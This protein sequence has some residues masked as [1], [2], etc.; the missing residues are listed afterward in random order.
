MSFK[1]I[2]EIDG[3]E[4]LLSRMRD[5]ET[6][7]DWSFILQDYLSF[8]NSKIADN[9]AIF[10][11]NAA[12]DCPNRES[13]NCQVPWEDC[14]AGKAERQYPQPL[15]YRRRQEYL[16]DSMPPELWAEAFLAVID[17][18][19]KPVDTIRF[20]EAGDFRHNADIVRVD[21]IA[22]ILADHGIDVY[23]YSASDYL[24]WSLAENF[25]VNAS[26]P[27]FDNANRRYMAVDAGE[28]LP[29]GAVWCPYDL[30]DGEK[31]CGD[32]KLCINPKGPDVAIP[33]H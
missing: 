33:M 26:N 5:A 9:V 29:D 31:K 16:W 27:W 24:D 30:S 10:N 12:S 28:E 19:R 6:V 15:A 23:T 20:S 1:P 8:G 22:D 32:C 7:R 11:M 4:Q 18:K 3:G 14:Y 17:R 25:T 13:E 21:T 2:T